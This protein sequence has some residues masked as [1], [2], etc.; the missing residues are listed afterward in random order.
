[1]ISIDWE[2]FCIGLVSSVPVS[3]LYFAGL[4]AGIRLAPLARSPANLLLL[5]ALCR[6]FLLLGVGLWIASGGNSFSHVIGYGLTFL[7]VRFAALHYAWKA[8]APMILMEKNTDAT[9]SR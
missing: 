2:G 5:S 4:A 1:M 3:M 8:H 7:L 6:F 9:H